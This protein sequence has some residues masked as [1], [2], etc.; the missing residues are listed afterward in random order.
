[1]ATFTSNQKIVQSEFVRLRSHR[2]QWAASYDVELGI[3]SMGMSG[4]YE[5]ALA[6]GSTMVRVGSLIFGRT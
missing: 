1:M 2:D 5:L 6:E 4:D 3:L